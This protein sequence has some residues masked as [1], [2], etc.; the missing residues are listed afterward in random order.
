MGVPP[1]ATP[2]PIPAL[3]IPL[4]ATEADLSGDGVI[5]FED[6]FEFVNYW[7]LGTQQQ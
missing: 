1:T 6:L 5:N 2:T 3:A 7:R 4:S